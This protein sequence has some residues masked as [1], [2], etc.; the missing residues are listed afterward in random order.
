MITIIVVLTVY[1]TTI[2]VDYAIIIK[3]H[4]LNGHILELPNNTFV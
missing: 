4:I 3:H 2:D 1:V